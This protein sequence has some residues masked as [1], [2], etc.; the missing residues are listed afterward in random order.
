MA[1]KWNESTAEAF[2]VDGSLRDLLVLG[3]TGE[4]WNRFFDWL[5]EHPWAPGASEGGPAA[6]VRG[7]PIPARF[8]ELD[9]SKSI[10]GTQVRYGPLT[11]NF[12]HFCDE[13]IEGDLDPRE[14]QG[15]AA[16][17]ALV[18]FVALLGSAMHCEVVV[19]PENG[20]HWTLLR[21]DPGTK[22]VDWINQR[23]G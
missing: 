10:W 16:L 7:E 5:R 13:E 1:I 8:D 14:V 20:R 21:Y 18:E 11:I 6:P 17:D 23:T 15:Q 22:S 3:V 9:P 4:V 19:T 12:H 2:E